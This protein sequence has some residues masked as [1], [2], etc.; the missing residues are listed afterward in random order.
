MSIGV[1]DETFRR[2][3]AGYGEALAD[4]ERIHR[5]RTGTVEGKLIEPDSATKSRISL[6]GPLVRLLVGSHVRIRLNDLARRFAQIEPALDPESSALGRAWF[7][8]HR[9]LVEDMSSHLPSLRVPGI[10]V[11]APFAIALITAMGNVSA[12]AWGVVILLVGGPAAIAMFG[13]IKAFRRKRELFLENATTTDRDTPQGQLEHS[14][15]NVYRLEEELFSLLGSRRRPES[16]ID[17]WTI[18]LGAIL[19]AEL[20]WSIPL[21]ATSSSTAIDIIGLIG[22]FAI[23]FAAIAVTAKLPKRIWR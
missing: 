7:A 5:S 13:L 3:M 4:A 12:H 6:F 9:A 21:W 18:S 22:G 10:F 1:L 16:Q 8:Q 20:S 17:G 11:V 23:L 19:L 15:R 2:L 14:G